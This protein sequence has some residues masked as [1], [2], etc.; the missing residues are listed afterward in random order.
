M[1]KWPI[2]NNRLETEWIRNTPNWIQDC[3]PAG[4]YFENSLEFRQRCWNAKSE[5]EKENLI[6]RRD[7]I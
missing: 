5:N 1:K 7:R 6:K 4:W 3:E 2:E